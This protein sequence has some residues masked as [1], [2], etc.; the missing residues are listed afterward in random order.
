[1]VDQWSCVMN[2]RSMVTMT[3]T[4]ALL[5]W[6]ETDLRNGDGVTWHERIAET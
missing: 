6:V 5:P 4:V 1:M 3:M 2:N